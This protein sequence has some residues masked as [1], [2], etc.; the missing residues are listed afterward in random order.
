MKKILL[1]LGLLC[2]FFSLKTN[3]QTQ[4]ISFYGTDGVVNAIRQYGNTVYIGGSFALVG[5]NLPY[6]SVVDLT[7]GLPGLTYAKP[8]GKV[9]IA[10][11]DGSGGWYIGGSFSK[12]G[13]VTRNSLARINADGS[14][15]AWDPNLNDAVYALAM[16]G[17]TIYAAGAFTTVNGTT[18]RNRLAAFDASTGVTT[19][20]NP[21]VNNSV[22]AI[23][24]SGSTLYAGGVFTSVNGTT[25]RNQ[26]AGIDLTT[27]VATAWNPGVNNAVNTIVVSGNIIYAGGS[28][29]TINTSITRNN[30]AA[31]DATTGTATSWNPN[32][33]GAVNSLVVNGSNIYLGGAFTS[34]NGATARNYLA[35][36][37]A[38][39]GIATAWN[40]N[41]NN[42]VNTLSFNSNTIYAGGQFTTVNA[43]AR[44]YLAAI[45]GGTG[46]VTSWDPS[47]NNSV[48]ILAISGTSVYVGGVFKFMDARTRNNIAAIDA[49]TGRTTSWDPNANFTVRSLIA[50]QNV[51]YAAGNFTTMNGGTVRNRIACI[52]T[53]TGVVTPWNPNVNGQINAIAM[54]TNT[55]NTLCLGG[56]F[57]VVNGST[58]RNK[59]AA[60]DMITG[61][62][63]AWDPNVSS[64][65]TCLA[66]SDNTV[67]AGGAFHFVNGT[68]VRNF[69]AA[70]DGTSGT[71]TGWN[72]DANSTILDLKINNNTVYLAGAFTLINSA[73][74]RNYLAAV[75][76]ATGTATSWNPSAS[77]I[78]S[79][80]ALS[81]NTL[82]A[83]GNFASINGQGRNNLGAVDLAT[84][85]ATPWN[86]DV[87]GGTVEVIELAGS[88]LY[89]GGDFTTVNGNPTN[90]LA[91]FSGI[92]S[93]T[94]PA[95]NTQPTAQS[96][97]EGSDI[98]FTVAASGTNLTYQ[99]RNGANAISGATSPNLTLNN[100]QLSSTGGS[101]NVVVSSGS[102]STTSN[103]A[104]LTV[105]A[106]PVPAFSVTSPQCTGGAY[107]YNNTSV[108]SNG[109]IAGTFWDFNDGTTSTIV[110]P[111]HIFIAQGSY[112][113]KLISMSNNGCKDS[114]TKTVV[115]N[116][117]TAID[118]VNAGINEAYLFPNLVRATAILR[119]QSE[120]RLQTSWIVVD[121]GGSAVMRFQKEINPGRNDINIDLSKLSPGVY[122][123]Q[124]ANSKESKIIRFVKL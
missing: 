63:T 37:D 3:A 64:T 51:V 98:I 12:I 56:S 54:S 33:N 75:D 70:I 100:V 42:I 111:V 23:A 38:G 110:N 74:T 6:G 32:A 44:N 41:P 90:K 122:Q 72:P 2:A 99:W 53:A 104:T 103:A 78:T 26:L 29:N 9:S 120:K 16:I 20:W 47:A 58:N 11:P 35:A 76:M 68:T 107:A 84:G 27:G 34:L 5:A 22:N 95:I 65:V 57:T 60:V 115:V 101:Y 59:I 40:P 10:I 49:I 79:S 96:V 14:V 93:C 67:Y 43:T 4:N 7:T 45:D 21:N 108:I 30:I 62:A 118:P 52:Y 123:L 88:S 109:T 1:L 124:Q 97:C 81:G 121:A 112:N 28:F 17:N 18:T 116:T 102:C 48:S 117:C 15:N 46:V 92:A 91:A 89:A 19:A 73:T 83:G 69:A 8:N 105:N 24:I 113:V 66:V 13:S 114:L 119:I 71:A 50:S 80:I 106:R 85:Q 36:V 94:N 87:A 25:V 86:P 55:P 39:T 61:I 82:Y 31:I 77:Y